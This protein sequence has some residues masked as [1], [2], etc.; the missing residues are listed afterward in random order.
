MPTLAEGARLTL[1][2]MRLEVE[3]LKMAIES[4]TAQA[5]YWRGKHAREDENHARDKLRETAADNG[6]LW[7]IRE[8][9]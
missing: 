5:Q 7:V 8:A 9:T 1:E 4:N 3:A 6:E 2:K